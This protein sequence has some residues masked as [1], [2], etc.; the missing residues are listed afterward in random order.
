MLLD[1]GLPDDSGIFTLASACR[2]SDD[3]PIIVL[4]ADSDRSLAMAA[5]EAG[6]QDYVIKDR[7]D[8]N[9]VPGLVR[10]AIERHDRRPS[11]APTPLPET[12]RIHEAVRDATTG[13]ANATLGA[14]EY[15]FTSRR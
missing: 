12:E 2:F 3:L 10:R 1:L 6:A 13:L 7:V 14:G 11:L 5:T 4:T 15:Q 9:N 8:R